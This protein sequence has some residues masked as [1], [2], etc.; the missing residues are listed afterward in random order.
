MSQK[1]MKW[2]G[3]KFY[4]KQKLTNGNY[5]DRIKGRSK[6]MIIQVT[7]RRLVYDIIR[8]EGT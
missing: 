6:E 5:I 4:G 7:E 2:K 3:L 1:E 8:D